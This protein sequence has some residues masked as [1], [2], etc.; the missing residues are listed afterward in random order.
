MPQ[1][2]PHHPLTSP[3]PCIPHA[4]LSTLSTLSPLPSLF[5]SPTHPHPT[6][7]DP[8]S[9]P[10]TAAKPALLTLHALF[11]HILLPALDLLDRGFVTRV[12]YKAEASSALGVG[13][14]QRGREREGREWEREGDGD[15]GE[16]GKGER[17]GVGGRERE[18][19]RGG[20]GGRERER[21]RGAGE[22]AQEARLDDDEEKPRRSPLPFENDIHNPNPNPNNHQNPPRT[23]ERIIYYVQ[24]S[25]SSI[26]HQSAARSSRYPNRNKGRG[27]VDMGAAAGAATSSWYEVRTQAWSCTCK[28]WAFGAYGAG[29]GERYVDYVDYDDADYEAY[30]AH[31]KKISLDNNNNKNP[32][33]G[34]E[35]ADGEALGNGQEGKRWR[36]G[37]LML[38][39]E[40]RDA[41]GPLCKHLFAC[42]LAERW[43]V[44]GGLV[45]EREVGREEVGGWGGGWGG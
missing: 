26:A 10:L 34:Q 5:P 27:R 43:G 38:E 14:E 11:P 1:S 18:K 19:E 32:E 16:E 25:S 24:S 15:G 4:L 7:L 44:A 28:A 41:N 39:E 36:W 40:H 3:S 37:S 30:K 31:D 29:G 8:N 35:A 12:R 17:G 23:K 33:R 9:D 22:A 45:G 2:S 20:V 6:N 13:E 21:E 42:V